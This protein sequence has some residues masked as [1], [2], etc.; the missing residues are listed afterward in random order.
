MRLKQ[1]RRCMMA[2]LLIGALQ[3]VQAYPASAQAPAQTG[4][5]TFS[6][7]DGGTT[8]DSV[9]TGRIKVEL[10]SVELPAGGMEFSVNP[11]ETFGLSEPG[12]QIGSPGISI[13]NRSVV[14]VRLEISDVAAMEEGDVT[15][16]QPFSDQVE[17][18]FQLKDRIAEVGAPGTAI[19]ALGLS[20][21][22]YRDEQEFEQYAI[23]PGR[24]GIFLTDIPAETG[25]ELKVYGKV[26]PDF[27][28]KYSFTVRP[29]LKISAVVAEPAD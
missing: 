27:Y 19:L 9:L 1:G 28:G 3:T 24:G 12:A 20:G 2:V 22:T 14:P 10:I 11:E 26:M 7:W 16:E 6:P 13:R 15:F 18:S 17:Q 5:V 29:T 25:V 8:S 23:V 4:E 21:R